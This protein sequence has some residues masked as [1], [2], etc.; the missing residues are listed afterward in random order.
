MTKK[1][2]KLHNLS[3]SQKEDL[4]NASDLCIFAYL[5]VEDLVLHDIEVH[6]EEAGL[7]GGAEG[8]ALHQA[9]L[10]VGGLVAEEVF[11][12][13]N[14]VLQNLKREGINQLKRIQKDCVSLSLI[15][16]SKVTK[17]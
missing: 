17:H 3:N 10:G 16:K 14:H 1:I 2:N 8:V 15:K 11:L 4:I 5:C 6:G 9:D 12:R 13:R 7:Q